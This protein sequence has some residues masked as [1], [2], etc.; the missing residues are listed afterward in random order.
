MIVLKACHERFVTG[1]ATIEKI[2]TYIGEEI[3]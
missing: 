3:L 1:T 2:F